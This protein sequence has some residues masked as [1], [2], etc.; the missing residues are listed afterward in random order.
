MPL[1]LIHQ[2]KLVFH[3]AR[4][5]RLF[6]KPMAAWT[7]LVWLMGATLLAPLSLMIAAWHLRRLGGDGIVGNEDLYSWVF[8]PLGVSYL[9]FVGTFGSL[10][11]VIRFTGYFWILNNEREGREVGLRGLLVEGIRHSPCLVRLCVFALILGAL[12]LLPLTGDCRL[13]GC[14]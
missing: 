1:K 13:V 9:L 5:V 7:V 3:A 11:L 10:L 4:K 14:L 6:W 2:K 8:T 12:L